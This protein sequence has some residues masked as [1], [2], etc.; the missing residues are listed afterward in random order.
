MRLGIH[1]LVLFVAPLA[2]TRAVLVSG[3]TP[4]LLAL[5]AC[6][7]GGGGRLMVRTA[8]TAACVFVLVSSSLTLWIGAGPAGALG[9]RMTALACL[10]IVPFRLLDWQVLAD[11]LIEHLRL[12]Y[13]LVDVTVMGRRFMA[14]MRREAFEMLT[15][16]RI[17]AAGRPGRWLVRAPRVVAP[18][19]VAALRQAELTAC[20]LESRGFASGARRT[21]HRAAPIRIRD[22]CPLAGVAVLFV[23]FDAGSG[24]G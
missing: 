19:L 12:P 18:M 24:P 4:F 21:A 5:T 9:L 23:V 13:P 6:A 2:G 20:A 8:L 11:S 7:L 1:P 10:V 3:R 15:R 17:E 22:W 16:L 14:L